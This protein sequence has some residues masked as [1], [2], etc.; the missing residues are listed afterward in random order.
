[1][2]KCYP[3]PRV[4]VETRA[5][6]NFAREITWQHDTREPWRQHKWQ[7]FK[8]RSKGRAGS[9]L[10]LVSSSMHMPRWTHRGWPD[11]ILYNIHKE[12]SYHPTHRHMKLLSLWDPIK[13]R[14]RQYTTQTCSSGPNDRS[15]IDIGRGYHLG[16]PNF[17]SDHSSS[18]PSSILHFP[19]IA[20]PGLIL[21]HST[22]YSSHVVNT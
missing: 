9:Y 11:T 17:R 3:Y 15:L 5:N 19:L 7:Q 22:N 12:V 2:G 16:A 13:T 21:N 4:I 6:L 10:A 20:P 1:M 18:F 14:M 8:T